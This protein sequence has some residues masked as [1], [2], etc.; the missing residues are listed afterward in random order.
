MIKLILGGVIVGMANIIPGVSG[1]TMM[2]IFGIF[3]PVMT[4]ISEL[5]SPKGK[6][7]IKHIKYLAVLLVG[8]GIG[9]VVFANLMELALLYV[10]TQT[11]FCFVGMIAFSIPI[12]RKKEM[13]E[14][15]FKILPFLIGCAIIVTMVLLAPA[16]TDTII[17]EFPAISPLYIANLVFLGIVAGA[18]MFVPGVSGSM[19]LLIIGDYYLFNSLIANVT[20]FRLDILIPLGFMGVG[21]MAGIVLSSKATAWALKANHSATMSLILGLVIASCIMII[22]F[23]ATFDVTTIITS[24]LAVVIGAAAVTALEKL[25]R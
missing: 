19:L 8:V 22:P 23:N 11:K 14:D 10:P 15:K 24:V 5:L 13:S 9:L 2:A 4:A 25:V 17:T 21:I 12:L 7:K 6:D 1:G 3:G 20:T 16:E 18:A